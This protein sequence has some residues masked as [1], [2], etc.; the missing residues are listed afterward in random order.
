MSSV[1]FG[2]LATSIAKTSSK[3]TAEKEFVKLSATEK[4]N[5]KVSFVELPENTRKDILSRIES[6]TGNTKL[7]PIMIDEMYD[8]YI[9]GTDNV[10]GRTLQYLPKLAPIGPNTGVEKK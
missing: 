10:N 7:T 4:A 9:N 8:F 1:F 2:A 5:A 3:V 6:E